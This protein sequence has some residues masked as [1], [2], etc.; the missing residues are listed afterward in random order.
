MGRNN[1]EPA[2]AD[3]QGD[4]RVAG[5]A[6]A[7]GSG[8]LLGEVQ[9]LNR[10][11]IGEFVYHHRMI[12]SSW[13]DI[14]REVSKA[15]HQDFSPR[16]IYYYYN[17]FIDE[18]SEYAPANSTEQSLLIENDRLDRLQAALWPGAMQGDDRA[19]NA[20]VKVMGHR[21]KINGWD[22]VDLSQKFNHANVLIVGENQKDWIDALSQ[23]H[24]VTS[25][26]RDDGEEEE[27][28]P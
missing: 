23:H 28:T 15:T 18:V 6:L 19:V 5:G 4:A 8:S 27:V 9:E 20:I 17:R 12:G 26:V 22:K 25:G 7:E 16:D 1:S 10:E 3:H 24:Q 13:A 2:Q 14:S 11:A 21:S